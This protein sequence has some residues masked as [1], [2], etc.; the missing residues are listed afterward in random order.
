MKK[1]QYI[2]PEV[3]IVKLDIKQPVLIAGSLQN[4]EEINDENLFI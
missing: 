1:R 3:E 4:N 2:I